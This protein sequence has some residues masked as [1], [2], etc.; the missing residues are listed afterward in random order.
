[1]ALLALAGCGEDFS[2]AERR[3]IASLSLAELKPLAPDPTNRVADD[4]RAAAFGATLF[5][6]QRLSRDGNVACSTCHLSDR[7]FQD[8]RPFGVGIGETARR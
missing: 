1:M 5:F 8:D 3:T 4:Q 2:E 7:Q 6:E